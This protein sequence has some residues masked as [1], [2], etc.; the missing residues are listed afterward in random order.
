ML[1]KPKIKDF[2]R[3]AE[4]KSLRSLCTYLVNGLTRTFAP[5]AT[6]AGAMHSIER[7]SLREL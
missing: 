2:V 5:R 3:V 6:L 1:N 4:I 7:E